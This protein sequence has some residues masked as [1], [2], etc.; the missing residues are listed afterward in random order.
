MMYDDDEFVSMV[1]DANLNCLNQFSGFLVNRLKTAM[2][3]TKLATLL[4]GLDQVLYCGLPLAPE[5]EDWAI[6]QGLRTT[7][8]GLLPKGFLVNILC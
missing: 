7:V 3:D 8:S 2:N 4:K 1:V 5:Q 6:K